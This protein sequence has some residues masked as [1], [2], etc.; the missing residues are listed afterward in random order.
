[1]CIYVYRNVHIYKVLCMFV[2]TYIFI[3]AYTY[4]NKF[5][6]CASLMCP[7]IITGKFEITRRLIGDVCRSKWCAI[8]ADLLNS[9][10]FFF[11]HASLWLWTL[12]TWLHL[13]EKPFDQ[14]SSWTD[15]M[16]SGRVENMPQKLWFQ[17]EDTIWA[18]VLYVTRSSPQWGNYVIHWALC[19]IYKHTWVTFRF[20]YL[21]TNLL[22]RSNLDKKKPY[23]TCLKYWNFHFGVSTALLF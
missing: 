4:T 12:L 3:Y 15:Y 11:M 14:I 5:F 13:C 7:W 20:N 17:V 2:Y 10:M 22:T 18:F 1:M 9:L 21:S 8:K 6:M 19:A 16:V 23:S